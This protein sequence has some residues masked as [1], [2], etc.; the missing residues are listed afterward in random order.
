MM[1]PRSKDRAREEFEQ[2]VGSCADDLLRTGYLVV[3]DLAAAED[4][5]QECRFRIARR[6]HRVRTMDHSVA[7]ARRIL[8]NLALDGAA[9]LSRQRSELGHHDG[10]APEDRLDTGAA[11]QMGLV[12]SKMEL[13]HAV[14]GLPPRQRA[15]LVLRHF[16]DLFEA[17]TADVL[18]CSI[19]TVK[20]TTSR[21]LERVRQVLVKV[22]AHDH[23]FVPELVIDTKGAI[24]RE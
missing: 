2:F 5:V 9:H 13:V 19:G 21:A 14:G 3:W 8:I 23:T 7:Y 15:A 24:G 22:P 20:S 4:L 11:R 12:E 16:E 6:W 1:V 10:S 17:E 18:G